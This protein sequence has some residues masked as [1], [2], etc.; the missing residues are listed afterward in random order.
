MRGAVVVVA[1]AVALV[2]LATVLPGLEVDRWRDALLAGAALG[3]V[4]AFVWP[5]LAFVLVPLSVLTLGVGAIVVNAVLTVL[6]LDELPGVALSGPMTAV[7]VVIG[8]GAVTALLFSLLAIDDDA[9]FDQRMAARARRRARRARRRAA[10]GTA[11]GTTPG[12]VFVQID[13]LGE[14]VLRRALASGDLPTLYRWID[15]G[16]HRVLGWETGWSAQTGV[17]QC[18]ILH[19]NTHGMPAFRWVEKETGRLMVSNHPSSAAE[20]ERRHSD[21][22]GLLAD[23]GASYGNLFSGDADR[24]VMTMSVAGRVKE[25]RVGAGYG[26][27]FASPGNVARTVVDVVTDVVRE[28]RAAADQRRRG[29]QPRVP[30]GWSYAALR[31]FTTVV[32]RDVCVNGVIADVTDGRPAIYVNLLG[33]DEVSHHSGPERADT[34]AVLRDLDRQVARIARAVRWAPRPYHVVVLSDHGQTQGAT[35]RDRFGEGLPELVSRLAGRTAAVDPDSAAGRTESTAW[36][37]QVRPHGEDGDDAPELSAPSGVVVE[38][39]TGERDDDAGSVGPADLTV[40]ASGGLGLVT[41]PGPPRRLEL[42]EIEQRHPGLVDALRRHPGIG[43]VL[44]RS[45]EHGSL[46]LGAEGH[47][48]LAGTGGTSDALGRGPEHDEVVGVDPLAVFGPNA[49]RHVRRTDTEP[50]VADLMIN[51]RYDPEREDLCAFEEQVGSHGSL[52]GP[53]SRPFLLHPVVL[54]APDEPIVG[55]DEVYRVL[56]GW[57][58]ATIDRGAS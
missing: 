46:V 56:R 51:A 19:G 6:V 57:R 32:S 10:G 15:E 4:N 29:V 55:S 36:L 23:G 26:R 17:S 54:P 3:A 5:A 16:T 31:A 28:R 50:N 7:V 41:F 40:L 2:V 1:D 22:R 30:R 44:V 14:Q 37:R 9:W 27:Y 39:R 42:E 58:D 43:F 21:G 13:G 12:F 25:G 49:T 20:I 34:L 8:M 38:E 33:Y 18:G 52:G 53:Q 24:S 45:G 35:F 48:R 47:R 11:T